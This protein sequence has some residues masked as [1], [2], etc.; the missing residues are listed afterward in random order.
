MIPK[1]FWLAAASVAAMVVGATGPWARALGVV[2]VDGTDDGK[3]GW[4]V[5][6]AAAAAAVFLLLFLIVR[7]VLLFVFV[8]LAGAAAAATAGY[9]IGDIKSLAPSEGGS[10]VDTEWGIYLALAG[11][12]GLVLAAVAG[13]FSRRR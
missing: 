7:K 9:D 12:I 3:D 10:V 2:T 6:G 4:I 13:L 1:A 11:S 5:L 8:L